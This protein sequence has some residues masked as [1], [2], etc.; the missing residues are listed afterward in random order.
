[1]VIFKGFTSFYEE[2]NCCVKWPIVLDFLQKG[3]ILWL[4]SD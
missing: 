4:K 1:M 2:K 3:V